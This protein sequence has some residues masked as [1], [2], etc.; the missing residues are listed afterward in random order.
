MHFVWLPRHLAQ[1]WSFF[2]SRR[3]ANHL[4]V[5]TRASSSLSRSYARVVI[6]QSLGVTSRLPL[7]LFISPT[8]DPE[9]RRYSSGQLA[10]EA[11]HVAF[12]MCLLYYLWIA[13]WHGV[14]NFPYLS[15]WYQ[16]QRARG[17]TERVLSLRES[18]TNLKS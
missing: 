8:T 9:T 11:C 10:A 6:W 12:D 1:A 15:L 18:T 16:K 14:R 4:D 13:T 3:G 17:L 7:S 5:L 2:L